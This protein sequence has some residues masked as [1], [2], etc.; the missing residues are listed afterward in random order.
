MYAFSGQRT[1]KGKVGRDREVMSKGQLGLRILENWRRPSTQVSR[2]GYGP[3]ALSWADCTLA[4]P[5]EQI[6]LHPSGLPWGL[7]FRSRRAFGLF[8]LTSP[9][10]TVCSWSCA[11]CEQ[12]MVSKSHLHCPLRLQQAGCRAHCPV[13][14]SF[15]AGLW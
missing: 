1:L 5:S 11:L 14:V 12:P 6:P 4:N 15:A 13:C 8:L 9:S 2:K 7:S 10:M 3:P